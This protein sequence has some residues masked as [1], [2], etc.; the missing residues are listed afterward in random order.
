MRRRVSLRGWA[1]LIPAFLAFAAFTIVPLVQVI[2]YSTKKTNFVKT[3]NV[4]LAN[5]LAILSDP[6]F[7]TVLGS[8][9]LY[10]AII[11]VVE[12][13]GAVL[14]ALMIY[15][16]TTRFKR[17]VTVLICAPMFVSGLATV[18]ILQ[19]VFHSGPAGLA[20]RIL[21]VVGRAPV[22]WFS[23]RYSSIVIIS[24]LCVWS[25][26]G[27]YAIYALAH[28]QSVGPGMLDAARIDGASQG[29]IR[30]RLLLPLL[31]PAIV[32]MAIIIALG[33]F[34]II[35]YV[36]LLTRGQYGTGNLMY[37]I[38]EMGFERGMYGYASALNIILIAVAM[39]LTL[40]RKAVRE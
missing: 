32:T 11:T 10:V 37:L 6:A 12:V 19:Y 22:E 14:I 21:G 18:P 39:A 16:M 2:V 38:W 33:S 31:K 7:Y 26:V 5:Y 29:Q 15:D 40:M 13:T 9:L 35:E 8:S 4:G 23:E 28:L 30:R 27:T 20:N 1:L 24:L 3:E 36:F 34:F 17:W 25:G